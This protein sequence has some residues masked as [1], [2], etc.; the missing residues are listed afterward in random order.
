MVGDGIWMSGLCFCATD[1]AFELFEG[2]LNLPTYIP[3]IDDLQLRSMLVG[4]L[5]AKNWETSVSKSAPMKTPFVL[6]VYFVVKQKAREF[7]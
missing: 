4:C 6:F 3:S 1:I 5:S 7:G 2:C